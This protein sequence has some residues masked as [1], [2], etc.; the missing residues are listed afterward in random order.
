[1]SVR[2]EV[3]DMAPVLS[4]V[5]E[6]GRMLLESRLICT[7]SLTRESI[8]FRRWNVLLAEMQTNKHLFYWMLVVN[9]CQL[10]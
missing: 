4:N 2:P 10:V 3:L 9:G 8:Q 6:V 5:V 1:M 7:G